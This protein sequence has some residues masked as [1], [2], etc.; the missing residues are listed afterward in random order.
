MR[1]AVALALVAVFALPVTAAAQMP[2]TEVYRG[3]V[4]SAGG[5]ALLSVPERVARQDVVAALRRN[6]CEPTTLALSV[7]GQLVAYI[8]GAPEFVNSRFPTSLAAGSAL[9]ARCERP[10]IE[11]PDE[12]LLALVTK[13]HS[14]PDGYVPES[15]V[16][17]PADLVVPGSGEHRLTEE[18]LDALERML[19]AAREAG[20]ELV[21]RSAYRSY[22]EQVATYQHWVLTLGE[23][24]AQRRSA[25]PGHSEHQLGTVVDLTSPTLSWQLESVL[26]E[27][28]EGRWLARNAR[29]FG[30][31]ESYP[32]GGEEVTGYTYEPWHLRYIG[33]THAEWLQLGGMTLTEYLTALHEELR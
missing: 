19:A 1:R 3:S 27:M 15:L 26:G 30:F 28:P 10:R 11:V 23:A 2:A 24:E 16:V 5:I 29:R 21:V 4:P 22:Q 25:T 20:H 17:L 33:E 9:V 13:E 18:A 12:H 6:G 8:P 31:V 14:L 7:Q 32:A